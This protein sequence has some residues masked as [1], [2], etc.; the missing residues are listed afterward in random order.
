[1]AKVRVLIVEDEVI[2][3][4]D[5]SMRLQN[6]GYEIVAL[7]DTGKDALNLLSQNEVDLVL[8]DICLIGEMDGITTAER[9]RESYEL[10]IIYLTSL[11]DQST[12]KRAQLTKPSAY[13]LKP[14][15]ER[16]LQIA[17]DMAI[18]NFS[19]GK[20]VE[21]PTLAIEKM[22]VEEGQYF[23]NRSIFVKEQMKYHRLDL[24]DI[25]WAEASGNYT[26]LKTE[27]KEYLFTLNLSKLE[28]RLTS[29]SF[30]RTHRSFF[31]NLN[32]V[33][34]FSG[35]RLFVGKK[36]ISVSKAYHET[37]FRHFPK[38]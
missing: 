11:S 18:A 35:N 13:M 38:L 27:E 31:V 24:E 32:H 21:N 33:S 6:M 15:N 5:I 3:A 17:I 23:S 29:P 10:P 16:E 2:V 37:V 1:M 26:I 22:P 12:V 14:F 20:I 8:L 30:I 9:I 28:E 4:E 7:V 36:E 19:E 34:A 25:L